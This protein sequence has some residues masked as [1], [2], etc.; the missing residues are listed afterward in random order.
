MLALTLDAECERGDAVL[1]LHVRKAGMKAARGRMRVWD[2]SWRWGASAERVL[3]MDAR[4][5]LVHVLGW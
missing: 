2:L 3:K 5:K 1:S 4:R